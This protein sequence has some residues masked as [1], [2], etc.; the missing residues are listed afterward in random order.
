M[1]K[2]KDILIENLISGDRPIDIAQWLIVFPTS[3]E[4]TSS[5]LSTYTEQLKTIY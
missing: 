4:N 3:A 2:L 5:V 1:E